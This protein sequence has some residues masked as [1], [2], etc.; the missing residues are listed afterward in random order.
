MA[1]LSFL[2][3]R[4]SPFVPPHSRSEASFTGSRGTI[5]A[6]L[7]LGCGIPS[8]IL[9]NNPF[10]L[11]S[12]PKEVQRSLKVLLSFGLSKESLVSVVSSSPRLLEPGL[13]EKWEI[14]FSRLGFPRAQRILEQSWR[15]G[16]DEEDTRRSCLALFEAGFGQ[17]TVAKVLEEFPFA[18][19]NLPEIGRRV[20]LLKEI[21]ISKEGIER[22]VFS[23][24]GFLLWNVDSRLQPLLDELVVLNLSK[25]EIC[26]NLVE[27]PRILF[28]M[29]PGELHR[30]VDLLMNLKCRLP[31]KE[32][33]LSKGAIHAGIRAKIFIDLLFC[34]GLIRR[35][36]L[37]VLWK[38]PRVILYEI[39]DIKKKIDF[40]IHTMNLTIHSLVEVPEFLGVNLEKQVIPRYN[41]VKH[42]RS[43]KAL[44]LQIDLRLLIKSSRMKFYNMFVKPYPECMDI[45]KPQK[46]DYKMKT[47]HPKGLWMLFKPPTHLQTR[48]DIRNVKYFMDSLVG[49]Q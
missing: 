42:L 2:R 28:S 35:E 21:G 25:N 15:S 44:A 23:F 33:I 36:A 14:V 37:T 22:I 47:R 49:M 24:P 13:F 17:K 5:I 45:F 32:K 12:D 30:Y 43:R 7:L 39:E 41:V 1:L 46:E 9:Q 29:D 26:R 20:D 16:I 38:E 11:D 31:I 48:D 10:L 40:L 19:M 8:S 34:H 4:F 6:N 27:N 18:P 3:R